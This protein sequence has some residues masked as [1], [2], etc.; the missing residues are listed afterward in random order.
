MCKN[1]V[2]VLVMVCILAVGSASGVVFFQENFDGRTVG[3][4]ITPPIEPAA[5]VGEFYDYWK[6][7]LNLYSNT[8]VENSP[9]PAYAGDQ[10][11]KIAR[12][13]GLDQTWLDGWGD[14]GAGWGGKTVIV[15]QPV[16]LNQ[17]WAGECYFT[18]GQGHPAGWT[19]GAGTIQVA[20]LGGWDD[21]GIVPF[22]NEWDTMKFV[23]RLQDDGPGTWGP[24]YEMM[25]GDYDLYLTR[26]SGQTITLGEGLIMPSFNTDGWGRLELRAVYDTSFYVDNLKMEIVPEPMTIS[27]L[28]LGVLGLIR[29][30]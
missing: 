13:T 18:G 21:T 4:P 15:T 9:V 17:A 23:I 19:T 8:M 29:R 5:Q 16:Y 10:A 22:T 27:L 25:S 14:M 20:N 12:G 28:G 7:E 11:L 26:P 2:V 6:Q 30:K 3:Q 1:V 24:G